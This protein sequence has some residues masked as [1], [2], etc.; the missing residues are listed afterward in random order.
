LPLLLNPNKGIS[1]EFENLHGLLSNNNM[2]FPI[3]KLFQGPPL[4]PKITLFCPENGEI[5]KK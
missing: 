5:S 4:P 1:E 2:R 3:K